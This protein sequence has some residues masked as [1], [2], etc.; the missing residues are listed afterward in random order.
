[1]GQSVKKQWGVGGMGREPGKCAAAR[2][3]LRANVTSNLLQ[4]TSNVQLKCTI[5]MYNSIDLVDLPPSP[6]A[7]STKIKTLKNQLFFS[8][9]LIPKRRFPMSPEGSGPHAADSPF[10]GGGVGRPPK[11]NE[12]V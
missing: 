3:C 1:M 8:T 6:R 4:L 7:F 9:F 12:F 2:S 5:Q 11:F 10:G